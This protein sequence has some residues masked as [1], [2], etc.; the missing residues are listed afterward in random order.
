MINNIEIAARIIK[1]G[2]LVAFPTETVYG[3]GADASNDAAVAKIFKIKQRPN[4]NPLIVHV[5][6]IEQAK[7]I[8]EFNDDAYKLS[9]LWPGPLTMVLPL[10]SAANIAP[11]VLAGLS[12][13]AIRIPAHKVA[14]ELITKSCCMLAAPSANPS[15]YISATKHTHVL[16]HFSQQDVLVLEDSNQ[17]EYGLESTIIDLSGEVPAILRYGFITPELLESIIGK[18]IIQRPHL[19]A[20]KAPGMLYKH[21]APQTQIRLNTD[22]LQENEIGLNFGSSNLHGTF[23][24]NLSEQCNLAEAASNLY[25]DLRQLDNYA[26]LNKI[27]RIA[28]APIPDVGIGLAI[29]DRLKRASSIKH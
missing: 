11:L 22:C 12:T 9:S 17:C 14:L 7:N 2:G 24:I 21:Y 18:D 23:S 20:I 28:V 6:D 15:G 4:I 26:I 16:E 13:V 25:S 8:G 3:I 10:N 5:A 29:N 27:T 1:S 19:M